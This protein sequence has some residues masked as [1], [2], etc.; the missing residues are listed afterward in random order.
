MNRAQL[1]V[2]ALALA[3]ALPLA[4]ADEPKAE[5]AKKPAARKAAAKKPAAAAPAAA[6]PAVGTLDAAPERKFGTQKEPC[7]Y[8]PVMTAQDLEN[9]K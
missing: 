8:K 7:V 3:F 2:A 4:A 5:P 9:C 6:T 1:I